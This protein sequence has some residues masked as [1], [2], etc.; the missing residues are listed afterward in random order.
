VTIAETLRKEVLRADSL[1][2]VAKGADL[3]Y[4]TIHTFAHGGDLRV[5]TADV[6]AAHFGYRLVKKA[7]RKR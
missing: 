3:N 2:A 7:G 5:S 6:L 1:Y 4:A